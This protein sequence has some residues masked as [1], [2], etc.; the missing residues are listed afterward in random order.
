MESLLLEGLLIRYW[1]HL[2]IGA[3][4]VFLLWKVGNALYEAGE[5]AATA[6]YE[7]V[8]ADFARS[9][10]D[11]Q[12]KARAEE[13]AKASALAQVAEEYERGKKDGKASADRIVADLLAGNQRLRDI[14]QGH[15]AT[16]RVSGTAASPGEFDAEARLRAES[17][18]RIIGAVAECEAQVTGLQAIVNEDRK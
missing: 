2:L 14:W 5:N 13:Q 7:K 9:E 15:Q 3:L 1:P 11:A 17:A 4:A 6:K 12:E 8:I 10:A 16:D 18:G